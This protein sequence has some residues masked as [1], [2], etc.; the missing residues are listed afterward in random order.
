MQYFF[1][2]AP[3]VYGSSRARDL[4]QAATAAYATAAA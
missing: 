1:M 2:V 3:A 4:I